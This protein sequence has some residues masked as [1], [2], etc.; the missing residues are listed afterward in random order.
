MPNETVRE[1]GRFRFR[2]LLSTGEAER[3]AVNDM[4]AFVIRNRADH[5]IQ[6]RNFFRLNVAYQV[7]E[8]DA[9]GVG[10]GHPVAWSAASGMAR[11]RG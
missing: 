4:L 3:C 11:L 10:D 1:P 5:C 9:E 8:F 2:Y 7:N 6:R